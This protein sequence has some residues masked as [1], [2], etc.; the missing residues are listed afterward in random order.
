MGAELEHWER[1][2]PSP[3]RQSR[4]DVHLRFMV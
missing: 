3:I 1:L 4:R 2:L